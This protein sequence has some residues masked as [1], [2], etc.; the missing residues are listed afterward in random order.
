MGLVA[1]ATELKRELPSNAQ[2]ILQPKQVY[3]LLIAALVHDVDHRGRNNTFI[4]ST[5][6]DMMSAYGTGIKLVSVLH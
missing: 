4:L 6:K 1:T 3:A 2:S 5:Q